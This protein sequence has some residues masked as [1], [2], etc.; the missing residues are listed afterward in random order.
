MLF[1]NSEGLEQHESEYMMNCTFNVEPIGIDVN[2]GLRSVPRY[3]YQVIKRACEN[4]LH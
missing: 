2:C 3:I 4:L 1:Q